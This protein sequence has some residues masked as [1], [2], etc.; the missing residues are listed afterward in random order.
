MLPA[1]PVEALPAAPVVATTAGR[2]ARRK[3][4]T[5]GRAANVP[6]GKLIAATARRHGL[7][8]SLFTALV[9]QESGFKVRAR[10]RV[11]AMGLTQLMP[12]TARGLGVKNPWSAAQNLNGGAKYLK[13]QLRRFGSARLALAAYNAG[14]RRRLALPRRPAVRRDAQL[15]QAHPR[16]PGAPEERRRPLARGARLADPVDDRADAARQAVVAEDRHDG[17]AA[18]AR[19]GVQPRSH[20]TTRRR[21]SDVHGAFQRAVRRIGWTSTS[22]CPGS[23]VRSRPSIVGVGRVRFRRSVASVQSKTRGSSTG[24]SEF[25]YRTPLGM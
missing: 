17:L 2:R 4:T 9:W 20:C 5:T 6:Y 11:G 3:R 1:T 14:P 12:A 7:S 15:R 8:V 13:A 25:A 23:S 19:I 21:T 16:P 24:P 18:D 22:S 10:S